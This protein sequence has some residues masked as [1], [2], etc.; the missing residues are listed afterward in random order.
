MSPSQKQRAAY[1]LRSAARLAREA[2]D[3]LSRGEMDRVVR[4]T[5]ECVELYLK[6]C[7]LEMGIEPAKTHDLV[8]LARDAGGIPGVSEDW[9]DY[10]V[11]QRIPAFYGAAD[12]IPDEVYSEEDGSR[13][14]TI[15][16]ALNL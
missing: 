15:L 14:M 2:R 13:C 4:K 7:L 6:G 8:M 11:Q 9:L 1:F 3:S 5:H 10:L 12:M 16:A